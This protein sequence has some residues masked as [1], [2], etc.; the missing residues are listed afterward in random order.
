MDGITKKDILRVK[1]NSQGESNYLWEVN[2]NHKEKK[3]LLK[4]KNPHLK[5]SYIP[6]ILNENVKHFHGENDRMYQ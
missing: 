6:I 4:E 3:I 2:E 5:M 1:R